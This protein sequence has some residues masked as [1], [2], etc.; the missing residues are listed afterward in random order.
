MHFARVAITLQK[1]ED[2]ARDNHGVVP[3][4]P[5][6]PGKEAMTGVVVVGNIAKRIKNFFGK[7]VKIL[8]NYG[9]EFASTF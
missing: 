5:D 3:A 4:Y 6:C 1:D 8:Q 9:H 7:S 2:S